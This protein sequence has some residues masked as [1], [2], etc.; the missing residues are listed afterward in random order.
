M[1]TIG[2][3]IEVMNGGAKQTRGGYTKKTLRYTKGG[4]IVPVRLLKGGLSSLKGLKEAAQKK[5]N[6]LKKREMNYKKTQD[7]HRCVNS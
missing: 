7:S 2:P 3:R 6:E 4:N 5:R 1:K